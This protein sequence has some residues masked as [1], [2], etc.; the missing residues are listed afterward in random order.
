MVAFSESLRRELR[1]TG[2]DVLHL[3]TPGVATDMLDDT[4]EVY[5][6]HMTRGRLGRL[7]PEEWAAK[8]VRAIENDASRAR[9]GWEAGAVAKLASRG[10]AFLMD[11]ISERIV[12]PRA[13]R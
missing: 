5:G 9:P 6:R 3:V 7:Q 4:R 11:A 8:V 12:Q 10:P 13:A 1:G 2:V